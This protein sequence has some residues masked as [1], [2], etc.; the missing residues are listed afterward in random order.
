L[1]PQR[2]KKNKDEKKEKAKNLNLKVNFNSFGLKTAQ[3]RH[4]EQKKKSIP[5]T[6]VC[7]PS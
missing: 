3:I 6:V 7:P 4:F 5:F 1:Q 2:Y